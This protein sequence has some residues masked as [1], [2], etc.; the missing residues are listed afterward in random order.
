MDNGKQISL[1]N[2][3]IVILQ[4]RGLHAVLVDGPN[5]HK[6]CAGPL[7]QVRQLKRPWDK[8]RKAN[9]QN[10]C[11]WGKIWLNDTDLPIFSVHLHVNVERCSS[12]TGPE[13]AL[14]Q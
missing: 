6:F 11:N 8:P 3:R 1:E 10:L 9:V 13:N 14:Q 4:Q 12:G 5:L 2:A 7:C